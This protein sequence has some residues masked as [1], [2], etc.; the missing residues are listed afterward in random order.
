MIVLGMCLIGVPFYQRRR[1]IIAVVMLPAMSIVLLSCGGGG[2]GGSSSPVPSISSLSPAQ[3]AAGSQVQNLYVNGSNFMTSS[4]VTYNGSLRNSSLQDS[5]QI[6][7][8]LGPNDVATVGQYPVVVTNPGGG[9]SAPVNF[10]IVNGTPT[11]YF[12]ASLNATTGPI[13]HSTSL[14]VVVQ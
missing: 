3:I 4:T 12:N 10:G 9:S 7:I 5:T 1:Q 8:A 11:G 2:G 14:V 13:T 6:Q